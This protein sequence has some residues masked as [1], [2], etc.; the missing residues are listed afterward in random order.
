MKKLALGTVLL[1]FSAATAGAQSIKTAVWN[2]S[3]GHLGCELRGRSCARQFTH[4]IF[5]D[6]TRRGARAK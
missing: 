4:D 6:V 2:S 3:I 5:R 1:L